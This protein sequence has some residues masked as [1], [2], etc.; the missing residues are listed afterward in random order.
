MF[1][2][3]VCPIRIK[4]KVAELK[5]ECFRHEEEISILENEMKNFLIFYKNIII[6]QL[7]ENQTKLL[8]KLSTG[9]FTANIS[10]LLCEHSFNKVKRESV[11]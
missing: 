11:A 3:V 8:D 4:K 10:L 6:P 7:K 5:N 2:I 9:E 1:S